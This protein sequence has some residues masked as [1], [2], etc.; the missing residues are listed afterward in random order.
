MRLVYVLPDRH[1]KYK[2]F[3]FIISNRG[4]KFLLNYSCLGVLR[5]FQSWTFLFFQVLP[6]SKSENVKKSEFLFFFDT[7]YVVQ[8][9]SYILHFLCNIET[10]K[11]WIRLFVSSRSS[12]QQFRGLLG[13]S[14]DKSLFIPCNCLRYILSKER[15]KNDHQNKLREEGSKPRFMSGSL[16]QSLRTGN[17]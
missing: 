16:D 5:V 17:F 3:T 10:C 1:T 15:C 8:M 2:W 11:S 7:V 4:Q 14:W 13:R 6:L 9:I 12:H